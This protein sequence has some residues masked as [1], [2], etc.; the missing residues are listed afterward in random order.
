M[1]DPIESGPKQFGFDLGD[2][3]PPANYE[4]DRDEV[5]AE[6]NDVLETTKA[7]TD[8][9]PWDDRTFQYHK[10]VFPQMARWLP[11]E[12]CS[13]LCFEFAREVERIELLMAA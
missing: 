5:R 4:P 11:E 3:P 13:Q 7:A 2:A 8:E 6:L 10:L 1:T 9:A 12:E